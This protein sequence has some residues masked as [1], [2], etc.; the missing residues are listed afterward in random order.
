MPPKAKITRDMILES[1]Y[2]LVRGEGIDKLTARN[3]S[4]R[5]G[6]STQPVLYYFSSVDEIKN[7]VYEIADRY[8]TEYIMPKGEGE[9]N[10]LMELG[11][12]YVRFARE[13]KYLFQLLFES[14]KFSNMRINDLINSS[15]LSQTISIVAAVSGQSEENAKNMFLSLFITAHGCASLL[16]GNRMEYEEDRIRRILEYSYNNMMM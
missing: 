2:E 7:E 16:A 9:E 11:L 13:E 3:I 5:L 12:N 10:P 6:C 8:H 14:D 4:L 15:E 1:S